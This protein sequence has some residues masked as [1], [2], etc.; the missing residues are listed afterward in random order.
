MTLYALV[1][2][3]CLIDGNCYENGI[4]LYYDLPSCQTEAAHQIAQG[5][6]SEKIRCQVIEDEVEYPNVRQTGE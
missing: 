3:V 4:E 1:M 6:P 2:S 5:I